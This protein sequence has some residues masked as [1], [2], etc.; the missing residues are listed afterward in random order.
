MAPRPSEICE[1]RDVERRYPPKIEPAACNV[2]T[3]VLLGQMTDELE[4]DV[5]TE[6]GSAGPKSYCYHTL[7]GKSEYKNKGTKSSFEI[8][9]TLNSVSMMNHIKRELTELGEERR[10]MEISIKNHFIRDNTNKTV[11]LTDLIK[12]FGVNWDKR[13]AEQGTGVTYPYGYVRM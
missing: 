6:F 10:L 3:G 2:S 9:Q 13:V 7:G 5:I 8:N 4:G 1:D 12:I 11:S